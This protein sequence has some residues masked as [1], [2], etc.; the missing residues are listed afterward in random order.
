MR[1]TLIWLKWGS[2]AFFFLVT[3]FF[4]EGLKMVKYKDSDHIASVLKARSHGWIYIVYAL[5]MQTD[6]IF[7]GTLRCSSLETQWWRLLM[8]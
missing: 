6:Q 3:V 7:P 8:T 2:S 5:S 1:V 4:Y